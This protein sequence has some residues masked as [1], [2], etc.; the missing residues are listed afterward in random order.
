MIDVEFLLKN[1]DFKNKIPIEEAIK[2]KNRIDSQ[3]K[4]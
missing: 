1:S 3:R 2:Y 4:I